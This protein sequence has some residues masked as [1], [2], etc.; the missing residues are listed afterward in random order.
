MK[1]MF[2]YAMMLMLAGITLSSCDWRYDDDEYVAN[3]L[4]YGSW[5]GY[6]GTYYENRWGEFVKDG[7]YH[8]V[9]R[10]EAA[11][12][13]NYG[14]ATWGYGS[15]VD[16]DIHDRRGNYAYCPFRWEVRNG[17]IYIDYD[18]PTWNDVRIDW[19]DYSISRSHFHGV[20]YDW[21]NRA[22]E[23][24]LDNTYWDWD[25]YDGYYD[26]YWART[27]AADGAAANSDDTYISDN[28]KSFATGA[29]AK[30]LNHKKT[31]AR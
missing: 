22:Y 27:R 6:L 20:M 7:D 23:F 26:R 17:N 29:F 15:E 21:D 31:L 5:E 18:D 2:Y 13:D 11:G 28:G 10:F 30:A 3:Y 12:Y 9:W 16:Y 19:R 4:T 1:K 14:Y 25:Y 24:D 8:T